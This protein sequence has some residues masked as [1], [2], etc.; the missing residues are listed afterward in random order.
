LYNRHLGG[1]NGLLKHPDAGFSLIC[2]G[3][4]VMKLL[5]FEENLQN[6]DLLPLIIEGK[7]DPEWQKHEDAPPLLGYHVLP[8]TQKIINATQAIKKGSYQHFFDQ[9]CFID[10]Q[11]MKDEEKEDL[12]DHRLVSSDGS[13]GILRVSI[14][15]AGDFVNFKM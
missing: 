4:Y 3:Y 11:H 9:Y 10:K 15:D 7:F 12:I 8:E 5:R 14:K 13:I 1:P 6:I 2:D